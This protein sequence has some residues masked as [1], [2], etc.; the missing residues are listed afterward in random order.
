MSSNTPIEEE[1]LELLSFKRVEFQ[2]DWIRIAKNDWIGFT[3]HGLDSYC[4]E[5]IG[6]VLQRRRIKIIMESR[7]ESVFKRVLL[8]LLIGIAR[9]IQANFSLCV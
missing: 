2:M 9:P 4:K 7:S 6:F 3:L 5:W 1:A 8:N